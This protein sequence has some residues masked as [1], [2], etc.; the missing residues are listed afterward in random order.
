[1]TDGGG[2]GNVVGAVSEAAFMTG[3]ER[4]G[5]VVTL[6]AYVSAHSTQRAACGV[7]KYLR[8]RL[9]LTAC[10]VQGTRQAG[11]TS[12]GLAGM[13]AMAASLSAGRPPLQAPLFVHWNNRPWP[14]NMIVIDNHRRA[15]GDLPGGRPCQ[16]QLCVPPSAGAR[17]QLL[18]R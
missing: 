11:G 1:M 3:M 17:P 6:G 16:E 9:R 15:Q 12:V 5:D 13:A 18:P 2:W 8:G 7:A 10:G 14:T 4:N